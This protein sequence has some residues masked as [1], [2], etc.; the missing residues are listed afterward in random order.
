VEKRV[1]LGPAEKHMEKGKV[2]LT[3]TEVTSDS[4]SHSTAI[5]LPEGMLDMIGTMMH[6]YRV[7]E[8][9]AFTVVLDVEEDR[10]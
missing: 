1:D 7:S 2:K 9:K 10:G 4:T 3:Y 8:S 6:N 5:Y